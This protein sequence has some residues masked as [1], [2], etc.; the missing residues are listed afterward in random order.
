LL[1]QQRLMRLTEAEAVAK[2]RGK[3][4]RMIRAMVDE[5]ITD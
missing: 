3:Y 5:A 2:G 1:L 4:Q